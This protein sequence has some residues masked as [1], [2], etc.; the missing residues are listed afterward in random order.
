MSNYSESLTDE[1]I[2]DFLKNWQRK[3]KL[4][5][6][7]LRGR[8]GGGFGGRGMTSDSYFRKSVIAKIQFV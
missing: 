3:M 5:Q 8:G 4:A 7:L 6:V 2:R 1:N